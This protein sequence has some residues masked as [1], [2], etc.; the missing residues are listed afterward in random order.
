MANR[1]AEV[2]DVETLVYQLVGAGSACWEN[3]G[4]AGQFDTDAAATIAEDGVERLNQL[5]GATTP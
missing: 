1:F 2:T 5:I 3:P 4:G